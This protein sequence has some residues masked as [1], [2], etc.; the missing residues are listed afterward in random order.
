MNHNSGSDIDSEGADHEVIHLKTTHNFPRWWWGSI[1]SVKLSFQI[2]PKYF[3]KVGTE[4]Y[5]TLD[6]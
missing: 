2:N 3:Q 4:F 5:Y 6:E 1:G